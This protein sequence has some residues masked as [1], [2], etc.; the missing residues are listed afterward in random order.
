M[1]R[2]EK[3]FSWVKLKEEEGKTGKLT[4]TID[5]VIMGYTSGEGKRTEFGIGQVL[6]GVQKGRLCLSQN[7]GPVPQRLS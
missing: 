2:E 4:D 1:N 5:A 3:G 7:S 6:L